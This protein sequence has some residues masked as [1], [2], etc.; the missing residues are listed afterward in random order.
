MPST[1]P[2]TQGGSTPPT[3]VASSTPVPIPPS[4]SRIQVEGRGKWSP[5][6][7]QT[8]C[9]ICVSCFAPGIDVALHRSVFHGPSFGG[10]VP[11]ITCLF[12]NCG[13]VRQG[14]WLDICAAQ[15]YHFY[16]EHTDEVNPVCEIG[17]SIDTGNIAII[18]H[19]LPRP[20]NPNAWLLPPKL[21]LTDTKSEAMTIFP[22]SARRLQFQVNDKTL[23]VFE[24]VEQAFSE[25]DMV[26][27][28]PLNWGEDRW[29]SQLVSR[30]SLLALPERER[31]RERGELPPASA[32]RKI[33]I[34]ASTSSVQIRRQRSFATSPTP[35]TRRTP[36]SSTPTPNPRT[37]RNAKTSGRQDLASE[38]TTTHEIVNGRVMIRVR[39]RRVI[40]DEMEVDLTDRVRESLGVDPEALRNRAASSQGVE[41]RAEGIVHRI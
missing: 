41:V 27:T 2:S 33:P 22:N 26:P 1:I 24:D 38:M 17:H 11:S 23:T 25:L 16:L 4:Q 37:L 18:P 40:Y 30:P 10:H 14:P 7:G 8:Y 13:Q 34:K 12:P 19:C 6:Q 3:C 28:A 29:L 39:R 32:N 31:E 9:G 21:S 35:L 36:G 5:P 15:V 20:A